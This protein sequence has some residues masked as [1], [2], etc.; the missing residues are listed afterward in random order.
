MNRYK[1]EYER[2]KKEGIELG[3]QIGYDQCKSDVI[4]LLKRNQD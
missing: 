4:E 1:E 3:K 2:G